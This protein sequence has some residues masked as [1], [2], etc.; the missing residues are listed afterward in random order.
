MSPKKKAAPKKTSKPAPKKKTVAKKK[1]AP[2]VKA[3]PRPAPK[4]KI[5]FFPEVKVYPDAETLV[6]EAAP[7]FMQVAR[8]AVHARGRFVAA[9]SGGTTPKGLFQ[10]L[11]EE[12]YK[13]L[14]PWDKT[15][16]FFVDER[17]VPFDHPDS[18][19][20]MTRE[21]LLSKVPIPAENVFP[22]TNAS[23][24]VDKAANSYQMK[25]RK[26][27]GGDSVPRFDLSLMGMGDD[28][29]TASL[30]PQVEQLNERE[31]WVV[32]YYVD[33]ARKERVSLTFPVLNASRLLLVLLSGEKKA[34]MA[35]EVLEGSALPPR[36][37]IQY[38][39][40][41]DGKLLFYL[42]KPAAALLKK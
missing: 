8:D 41:T 7:L 5:G 32:G 31:K 9:L 23:L 30:F 14:I 37:P 27:F 38:L 12:P 39:A 42:D 3:S 1:A 26:F 17:Q 2:K 15:F 33:E 24:P 28:G 35:K 16:F 34:S 21:F 18:N 25:L 40:P 4:K 29:H 36:Y 20:R 10:Q 22:M 19:Y 13:S 11:S 6:Q